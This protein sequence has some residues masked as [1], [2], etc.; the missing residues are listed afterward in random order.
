MTPLMAAEV[1]HAGDYG[2]AS[3]VVLEHG[4]PQNKLCPVAADVVQDIAAPCP[5]NSTGSCSMVLQ[6]SAVQILAYQGGT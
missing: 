3:R 6:S 1:R 4:H 5:P 2:V